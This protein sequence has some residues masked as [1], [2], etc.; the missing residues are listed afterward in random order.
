M[1]Q[2]MQTQRTPGKPSSTERG[3]Q[4]FLEYCAACHGVSAKGDGPAASALKIPPEDLT[5]LAAHN[6]G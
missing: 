3:K 2:Q 6:K 1:G 4:T 5:T